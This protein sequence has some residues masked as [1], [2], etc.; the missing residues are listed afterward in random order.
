LG[1]VGDSDGVCGGRFVRLIDGDVDGGLVAIVTPAMSQTVSL[2]VAVG[3]EMQSEFEALKN[4]ISFHVGLI[5]VSNPSHTEDRIKFVIL[6]C[7]GKRDP[8]DGVNVYGSG[9]KYVSEDPH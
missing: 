9:P 4:P 5:D 1:V 8:N 7:P 6:P 2:Y 3:N